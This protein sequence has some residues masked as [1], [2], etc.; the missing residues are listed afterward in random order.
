MWDLLCIQFNSVFYKYKK[1]ILI[2]IFLD[3]TVQPGT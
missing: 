3:I 1:Q 2:S